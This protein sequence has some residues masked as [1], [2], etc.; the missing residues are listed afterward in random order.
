MATIIVEKNFL[1]Y[2]LFFRVKKSQIFAYLFNQ[3]LFGSALI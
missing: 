1:W 3:D 2:F